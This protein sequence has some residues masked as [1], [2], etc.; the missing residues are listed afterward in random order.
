MEGGGR[1]CNFNVG[2]ATKIKHGSRPNFFVIL[3][4]EA[5]K[6]AEQKSRKNTKRAML[7]YFLRTFSMNLPLVLRF[8]YNKL[9][10]V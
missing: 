9:N 8:L 4:D 1:F 6:A 10:S 2:Y 7:R 5:G 3:A